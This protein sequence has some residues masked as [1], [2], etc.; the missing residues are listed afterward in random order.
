MKKK[1]LKSNFFLHSN[2]FWLKLQMG[3]VNL[4]HCQIN[5]LDKP[6]YILYIFLIRAIEKQKKRHKKNT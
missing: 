3:K 4:V 1:I 6:H 2:N 5:Y